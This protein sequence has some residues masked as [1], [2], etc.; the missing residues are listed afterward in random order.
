MSII[1]RGNEE[2]NRSCDHM[3]QQ[4]VSAIHIADSDIFVLDVDAGDG[5]V[6]EQEPAFQSV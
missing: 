5:T 3:S 6:V 1:A 2:F 4:K